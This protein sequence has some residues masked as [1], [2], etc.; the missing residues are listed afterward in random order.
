MDDISQRIKERRNEDVI[1]KW[2]LKD[3]KNGD[4]VLSS[5]PENYIS[6]TWTQRLKRK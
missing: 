2:P 3:K 1:K 4:V 5:L 6:W